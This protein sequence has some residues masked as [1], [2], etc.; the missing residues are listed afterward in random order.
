MN[1]A[2]RSR[3]LA[4]ALLAGVRGVFKR[5]AADPLVH[6]VVHQEVRRAVVWGTP[7]VGLYVPA[8][9]EVGGVAVFHSSRDPAEWMGRV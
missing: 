3:K 7:Y 9:T 2:D 5:V 4:A 6:G 1:N 8:D